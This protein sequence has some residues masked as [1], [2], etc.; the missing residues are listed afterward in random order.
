MLWDNIMYG[1][2]AYNLGWSTYTVDLFDNNVPFSGWVSN[3]D[4]SAMA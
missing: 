2:N 3:Y 1:T 4:G